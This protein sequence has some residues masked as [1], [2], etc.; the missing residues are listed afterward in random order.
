[1]QKAE[2]TDF[3]EAIRENVLEEPANKC[4]GVEGGGSWARTSRFMVGEGDG[5]V[6]EAHEA[7]VG[8]GD[9]EDIGGEVCEGR[10]A[11]GPRLRVD[12]PGEVPDLGGDV[13]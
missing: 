13:L 9:P 3:H 4:D 6:V 8:D 11:I 12:I 10:V 1:M 5:A 7:T 2:V